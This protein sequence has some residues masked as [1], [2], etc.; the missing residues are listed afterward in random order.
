MSATVNEFKVI[1]VNLRKLKNVRSSNL[2]TN[3][4]LLT[5]HVTVREKSGLFNLNT[6][7][8]IN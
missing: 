4:R 5:I 1:N 8:V 3:F 7:Y 6:F 2:K